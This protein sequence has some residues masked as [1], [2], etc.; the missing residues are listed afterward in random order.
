MILT[1]TVLHRFNLLLNSLV[2]ILKLVKVA[3]AV[4]RIILLIL[5]RFPPLSFLFFPLLSF[6]VLHFL[7]YFFLAFS[8]KSFQLF[9]LP[10]VFFLFFLILVCLACTPTDMRSLV[11]IFDI[12]F[13]FSAFVGLVATHLVMVCPIGYL[14]HY[15]T[16]LA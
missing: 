14:D 2:T 10:I 1:Y 9:L 16:E 12:A 5:L 11:L 4:P 7:L 13:A 8:L 15:A 6:L 3:Y